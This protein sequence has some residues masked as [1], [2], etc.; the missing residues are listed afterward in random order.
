MEKLKLLE[1]DSIKMIRSIPQICKRPA[2][3]WSTGK[4]STLMLYLVRKAFGHI[5]WPVIHIDTGKK[6]PEIYSFRDRLKLEWNLPLLIARNEEALALGISPDKVSRYDCCTML[7]TDALKKIVMERGFDA[8]I[9]SIRYDEHYVRGM[10]DLVSLRDAEGH[11]QY[12]GRFGGFGLTAPE[13][14]GYNHIRIH[15]ILPWTEAEVWEYTMLNNLPVNPLYFAREHDDGKWYRYRSLGCKPCTVPVESRATT[16]QEIV[17]EVWLTP[18][19]ERSGRTQDKETE[20][21]MLRLRAW[22]YM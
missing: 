19:I 21:A 18:G 8:L 12:W 15:A 4:D 17:N 13:K 7:K 2:Q 6:F 22:G 20:D 10:E 5:P 16:I 1:S 3:L 9:L 11:W 14:E